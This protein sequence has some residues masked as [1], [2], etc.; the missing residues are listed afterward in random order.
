MTTW[1][2]KTAL[3]DAESEKLDYI[4]ELFN[5]FKDKNIEQ[6]TNNNTE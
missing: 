4:S 2:K 6:P 1:N 5:K 3:T